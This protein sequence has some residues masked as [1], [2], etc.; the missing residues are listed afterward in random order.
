MRRIAVTGS[1]GTGKTTLVRALAER[2]ELPVVPEGM[3]AHLERTGIDL[4]DLGPV[5]LRELVEHLWE[6]RLEAEAG[7]AFVADRCS[8][9][10]AVFWLLYRFHHQVDADTER[11]M[12]AFRRYAST[13]DRILV[14]PFGAFEI[15]RDGIRAA[16]GWI[17]LH[18]QLVL[19]GLLERW[20]LGERVVRVP[21][22]GVS[23]RVEWI[24]G[25]PAH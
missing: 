5:R 10:F 8:V 22:Q 19:E 20:G 14:L 13:Y 2:L 12:A 23:R 7:G 3:R 9:D 18:F 15:E 16:N 4:H 6:E 21:V 11:Y 25:L 17:Q 24:L 1:A